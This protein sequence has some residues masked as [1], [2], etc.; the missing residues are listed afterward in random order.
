MKYIYEY[1]ITSYLNINHQA[2]IIK[3]NELDITLIQFLDKKGIILP[4][5]CYHEALSI[6]GNCRMCLIEVVGSTKPVIACA[7]PLGEG[8]EILTNSPL[9]KKA[10]E[11]V[12]EFLLINHPLDCPI[13]DQ[14]GE[15][16]LQDQ[17]L[18]FGSDRGRFEEIKRSVSDKNFGC[19]IKTIMTRCIHCTRCV[20]FMEEIIMEPM[21][22]MFGRGK[23]SEISI[24]NNNNIINNLSGNV[25]DL[26]PVGALTSKPYAFTARPWE[27]NSIESIDII[28]SL[29]S[30]II[31]YIKNNTIMRILPKVNP[32][33]NTFWISDMV[34]FMYDNF[35]YSRLLFPML[36][37]N[38]TDT[39]FSCSWHIV[40]QILLN[41]INNKILFVS[42]KNEDIETTFLLK[43]IA[44]CFGNNILIEGI[45]NRNTI[46][47][48]TN[49]QI[50][51]SFISSTNNILTNT[52]TLYII[53]QLF[54]YNTIPVLWYNLL[55]NNSNNIL[56]IGSCNNKN[57]LHIGI[58]N[59]NANLLYS[60][61]C[62]FGQKLFNYSNVYN[63]NNIN[64][65]V[66]NNFIKNINVLTN[67]GEMSMNYIGLSYNNDY[68]NNNDTNV[69]YLINTLNELSN[70]N[71]NKYKLII[72]QGS[73]LSLD[74]TKANILLPTANF[75]ED[76][77]L[78]LNIQGYF[79]RT[80]KSINLTNDVKTNKSLLISLINLLNLNV[81]LV[82]YFNF[83]QGKLLN[84]QFKF[85]LNYKNNILNGLNIEY[86]KE[87]YN[88]F[89][90]SSKFIINNVKIKKNENSFFFR[91]I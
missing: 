72:Y 65:I 35:K 78:Y 7:T 88:I 22:G 76:S 6:A 82:S 46:S 33:I 61:R 55:K 83:L 4:R 34:R 19:F 9:I 87:L 1:N 58:S 67:V 49:N 89:C 36:K 38:K 3:T 12:L 77:F 5:F 53:N 40:L 86:S 56:H 17:T 42:G 79:Q 43:I 59:I 27:L 30:N 10:R 45:K 63:Y 26:C 68:D 47:T 41:Y 32:E 39:F 51:M 57:I 60:G 69:I 73:H 16:D 11:S 52:N 20:R 25:I 71:D 37:D 62:F 50:I 54:L 24:Y 23:N 91:N 66:E 21:I 48:I 18:L 84:I 74:A 81:S 29:N 14:A 44:D 90:L 75:V 85:K 64:T 2:H 15:R 8:M 13:C 28:D 80:S 70:Y 31:V